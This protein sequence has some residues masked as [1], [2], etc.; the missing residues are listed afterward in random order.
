MANIFVVSI[1]NNRLIMAVAEKSL[2][3]SRLS[4]LYAVPSDNDETASE[5]LSS[6]LT[7]AEYDPDDDYL[8]ALFPAELLSYRLLEFPFDDPKKISA[9][10]A[11]ELGQVTP[12]EISEMVFDFAYVK[13]ENGGAKI[14]VFLAKREDVKNFIKKLGDSIAEP[15]ILVP[16]PFAI[17]G[18]EPL[19]GDGNKILIDVGKAPLIS[20]YKEGR[21]AAFNRL[22]R[23]ADE[24]NPKKIVANEVNRLLLSSGDSEFEIVL[25]GDDNC[26]GYAEELRSATGLEVFVAE[27]STHENVIL[28]SSVPEITDVA[29]RRFVPVI[30]LARL[31]SESC[32]SVVNLKDKSFAVRKKMSGRKEAMVAGIIFALIVILSSVSHFVETARLENRYNT[33]KKS[34]RNVFKKALP[35][36]RRIVSETAQLRSALDEYE[37]RKARLGI[38]GG[39]DQFLLRLEQI[40]RAVPDTVTLDTDDLVYEQDLI[41]IN[42]RTGTFEMVEQLKKAYGNLRFVSKV[43]VENTKASVGGSGVD[44][45]M[46]LETK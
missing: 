11:F 4:A 45:R 16:A 41:T 8:L 6:I 20:L 13:K 24:T 38:G 3:R 44:F 10:L 40:S 43:S 25:T 31:M 21:V 26:A 5:N 9:T 27:G 29:D 12:F 35:G 1:D 2:R 36:T 14:I 23:F 17:N 42:G 32:D 46:E 37:K 30:N 34:T 18:S 28:K 39:A 19:S 22:D 15:D 7:Q 33:I